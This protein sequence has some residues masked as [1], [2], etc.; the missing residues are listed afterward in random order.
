MS[1]LNVIKQVENL[2]HSRIVQK[3]WED[4]QDLTIHGWVYRLNTGLIHNLKVSRN[5]SDD[6][7]PVYRA[8]PQVS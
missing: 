1:E 8:T 3:A 4:G 7:E 5:A 2:S 6:I